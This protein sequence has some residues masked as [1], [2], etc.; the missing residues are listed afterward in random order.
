MGCRAYGDKII[1]VLY[2]RVSSADGQ[3]TD[4]Q[5]ILQ[6][7]F[8]LVVEDKCSGSVPFFER[9]GGSQILRMIKK[10]CQLKLS[11][12]QI[13]RLGRN[14]RDIINTIHYFSQRKISISF[15][16]QGLRTLDESGNENPISK[17]IIS[18]LGV[19]GEMEREQIRERQRE[20]V[21]LAKQRGIYKGRKPGTKESP[22][23]FLNKER[24]RQ[25]V[26]LIK[27][28]M[29]TAEVVKRT[30]L[31]YSTIVKLKN[32]WDYILQKEKGAK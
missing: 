32:T 14:L 6:E 23:V 2:V 11:V 24:Y 27:Q 5:R 29:K 25:V 3:K 15:E 7:Q 21:M 19:V 1:K 8:D 31:H 30:G 20:G 13:D 26:P 12:W 16:A 9:P 10:G 18:I 17:L 22:E 28:G 4:R